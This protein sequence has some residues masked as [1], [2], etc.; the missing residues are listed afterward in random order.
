M[1][2]L[3]LQENPLSEPV[4]TVVQNTGLGDWLVRYLAETT[5][6]VMGPRILMPEQA[7]RKFSSDYPTARRILSEERGLLF[8]DGMKLTLFKA[9]E[10]VLK[11]DDPVFAPIRQYLDGGG[12]ERLWQLS[13]ALAGIFYHYGMN[14]L[15]LVEAWDEDLRYS[16]ILDG[17][18]PSEAWQR[19]LWC[20]I[21]HKNA[22]Y[23]HLSRV[24]SEVMASGETLKDSPGPG[25]ETSPGRILLF[26]SMFLG[27]TGLRFFRYLA[28]DYEV[29]HFLLTP[30]RVFTGSSV[31]IQG[32]L[33]DEPGA[34]LD[35]LRDNGRLSA[36]FSS[37]FPDQ[38][39][40][41]PDLNWDNPGN[42]ATL[43]HR[44]RQSLIDDEP[45][46]GSLDDDGSI[47]VHNCTGPRRTVEILKDR[48]LETLAADETLAPTQIGVL[49]PD[50]SRF[51]PYIETVFPARSESGEILPGHLTFNIT[52]L[53]ARS[54][55]PYPSGFRTLTE[56]P[57]SRFGS[58]SLVGL[59]SNPCFSP[60]S[61]RPETAREW[62]RQVEDLFVRWG[63]DADHRSEEG[64]ADTRAG[65]WDTAFERLLAGYYYQEG[66]DPEILPAFLAGDGDADTAGEL[67]HTI[68][69][70]DRDIRGLDKKVLSL[71]DWTLLWENITDRWLK[72]RRDGVEGEED[73][74]DRLRIKAAI[75]DLMA[76][77]D[78][79]D[80]LED[81]H[82]AGIPWTAFS[83][84]LDEMTN[85]SN[86]RRG[87]YLSRGI[88][89]A[90]LKP[91]RAIPFRRI[92]V[93]GMDE[94]VW[95]GREYL[96][97]F[98]LRD[99]VPK[100]IDLSRE[101]VDRFAFLEILFSAADNVSFFY[102]GRDPE[103]GDPLSPAA[104]LSELL[105]HLGE[106]AE[107]LISRHPLNPFDPASLLGEGPLATSSPEALAFAESLFYGRGRPRESAS[108]LSEVEVPESIDW[109]ELVRFLRNPVEFFYHRSLGAAGDTDREEL[110][111]DDALE[112]GFLDWWKW[113]STHISADLEILKEPAR[114]VSSFRDRMI[115][116]GSLSETAVGKL[117]EETLLEDAT[118]L[119]SG[120]DRL[121]E[122]G[123]SMGE[124][125]SCRF[126]PCAEVSLDDCLTAPG[127]VINL[128]APIVSLSEGLDVQVTGLID[129]LRLLG[130]DTWTL[131][132]FIS[133]KTVSS[134]HN[135]RSW[136][137]ALMI[138][139][140]TAGITTTGRAPEELRVFRLSPQ[141]KPA[142]RY[143]FPFN[144]S[145]ESDNADG[146]DLT[147]LADPQGILDSLLNLF[148]KGN[149]EPLPM[150]PELADKLASLHA[151]KDV[152]EPVAEWLPR[153]AVEAWNS[154]LMNTRA[155]SSTLRDDYYRQR[156]LNAPDFGSSAFRSAWENI[157]R[158]GG[159]L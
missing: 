67:I 11:D 86:G 78:D 103:R 151:K 138:G 65:S 141:A 143:I 97:G 13:D 120:L 119:A 148:M 70:L 147:R 15:P 110:S 116:A 20:R 47:A 4:Y 152:E 44:L 84:L 106:G 88:T 60:S 2:E 145:N 124:P 102:T 31:K 36:G 61:R 157:Y 53:P 155:P 158:N 52:D 82:D 71:K 1:P 49:A 112:A 12:G 123:L 132:D 62:R 22:P 34:K 41:K 66:D 113:R 117:Q 54:E 101:S 129:G 90:S 28:G 83:S 16:G 74:L 115:L 95:P 69:E 122:D 87:R 133:G 144:V 79:V 153:A 5:G 100:S 128:P 29:H 104:P 137:A 89:C 107:K 131:L 156:Y 33:F 159:L 64:A 93:L 19:R 130:N 140:A 18:I 24:L 68:R 108:A 27:E 55:A 6:A 125:F 94:S 59:F 121:I 77:D 25:S 21:F 96:T 57:G 45:L 118:A 63:V 73:E 30:S 48:I 56:L 76:L 3:F 80:G 139:T 154:I 42:P 98:D 17:D 8:M 51:A 9:L 114:L 135:L 81:F 92:Y 58:A 23:T 91:M 40:Q 43:I 99:R 105:E 38:P 39:S 72:P 46:K 149:G 85:P 35:F 111:E 142:R 126:V 150:Y 109:Q 32:E 14:C 75:R 146:K 127:K 10:E 134:R 50:I 7:L 37:L 136:V 26:G